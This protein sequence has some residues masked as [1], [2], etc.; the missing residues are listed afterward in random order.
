MGWSMCTNYNKMVHL[1]RSLRMLDTLNYMICYT[2]T[3]SFMQLRTRITV[4]DLSS[5][6]SDSSA[7]LEQNFAVTLNQLVGSSNL[8]RPT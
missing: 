4:C 7:I 6:I 3:V 5:I 2:F 1:L 8:P